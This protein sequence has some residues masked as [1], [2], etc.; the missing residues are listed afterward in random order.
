[1]TNIQRPGEATAPGNADSTGPMSDTVTNT[2]LYH[3]PPCLEI[4]NG[5]GRT[6]TQMPVVAD[7]DE[8]MRTLRILCEPGQ[9]VE[10]RAL[11]VPLGRNG[12]K[13][14]HSGYFNDMNQLAEV[15]AKLSR[16]AAGVYITANP[17]AP[18]LLARASNHV[19][20]MGRDDHATR[21]DEIVKRTALLIDCDPVRPPGISSTDAEHEAA[22]KAA[23][24]IRNFLSDLG[25]PEPAIY[26]SSGN[27][28]H[29]VYRIDL[30]CDDEG[31][32]ERCLRALALRFDDDVVVVDT[33]VSNSG[34][35]CKLY[36]TVVRKGDDVPERP[37]RASKI[38][39]APDDVEIVSVAM[40]EK[41]A[42]RLPQEDYMPRKAASNSFDIDA[43]IQ[44]HN[45][46]VGPPREWKGG[47]RWLFDVCPWN[48]EH[49]NR[50]AF[51]LE[52][53]SG[54]LSAGCHHKSCRDK[55]WQDLR[56]MYEAGAHGHEFSNVSDT[57]TAIPGSAPDG[58]PL[59]DL[60]N[61]E[62][63]VS[64]HGA[65]L[66]F[67]VNA[68]CW[69]V[70]DGRRWGRR[71]RTSRPGSGRTRRARSRSATRSP[72]RTARRSSSPSRSR[73]TAGVRTASFQAAS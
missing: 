73:P 6:T 50:S 61:A 1:M 15:A 30:P 28:G 35:L 2:S 34:Q 12:Y 65:D 47:R 25:F 21:D 45:L 53:P 67:D 14:N 69:L 37:H 23:S 43:W 11:K 46:P 63:L 42:A 44:A 17:V 54:A 32:V 13:P 64:A 36:G 22:L 4:D 31:L 48:G 3:N 33:S 58:Y 72:I 7:L 8:I 18:E 68:G 29:L 49:T 26:A 41:L 27:G 20:Q 38:L 5:G 55:K 9:V 56:A 19:R 24:Q 71:S 62:R 60:G 66:R 51:I 10:L 52:F 40:L 70:W 16:T 39:Y 57:P 59:T